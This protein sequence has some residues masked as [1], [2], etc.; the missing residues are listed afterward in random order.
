MELRRSPDRL[1]DHVEMA[2]VCELDEECLKQVVAK[3]SFTRTYQDRRA[4]LDEIAPD[5]VHCVMNE[6]WLLQASPRL[7]RR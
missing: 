1:A 4:M 5:I 6:K 7:H 3:Y 2:A